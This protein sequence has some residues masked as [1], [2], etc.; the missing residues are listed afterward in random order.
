M[1]FLLLFGPLFSLAA[2]L[3]DDLMEVTV[4]TERD[5][6]RSED[7]VTT[8]ELE[9]AKQETEGLGEVLSRTPGLTV[10]RSGGLGSAQRIALD[11]F[12]GEQIRTFIDGVPL[13][14]SGVALQL[15][16]V[17]LELVDAVD[18]FHG[19]VPIRYGADALG[20]AIDLRTRELT[21]G[22]HGRVSFQAGSWDSYRVGASLR[23]LRHRVGF[24]ADATLDSSRNDWPITVGVADLTG[25]VSDLTVRRN[26]AAYLAGTGRLGLVVRDKPW[27]DSFD[28]HLSGS[29]SEKELPHNLVMTV[30]YGE[31]TYWRNAASALANWSKW[32]GASV[33]GYAMAAY[34]FRQTRLLDVAP[35]V[36]GWNGEIIRERPT[37]GELDN[38]P[39]DRVTWQHSFYGRLGAQALVHRRHCLDFSL[40]PDLAWRTGSE[41]ERE[42][43]DARDPGDA[44][45]Q[46]TKFVAGLAWRGELAPDRVF[47][48][49]FGKA[50]FFDARMEG[51]SPSYEFVEQRVGGVRGGGGALLRV[52]LADPLT[53]KASY[54]LATRIPSADE[55][56]GDGVLI[57][58]NLGLE[59]ETSH[60]ANLELML[61]GA[62]TTAGTFGASVRGFARFSDSLM[63]LL[64]QDVTLQWVNVYSA[65][66]LGVNGSVDWSSPGDWVSLYGSVGWNDMRNISDEGS[67]SNFKGDRIPNQPWLDAYGRLS[68]QAQD[69]GVEGQ[70]LRL[71][72]QTQYVHGY[73][74][75][76]ESVGQVASKQFVPSQL[77][78]GV[79]V[80]WST[81]WRDQYGLSATIEVANLTNAETYDLFGVQLAG[82]SVSA[83]L[84]ATW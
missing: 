31:V 17:P 58:P 53:L 57:L 72:W 19:V 68:F 79:G 15:S 47:L 16:D 14:Y 81:R 20:G 10:Q 46:L 60:N 77:V 52:Q 7:A 43:N 63:V 56:F 29:S 18:V 62:R 13:A 37:P 4:E 59:P 41:R 12:D 42:D 61:A 84:S 80:T 74:R 73:F 33:Q 39:H 54:E 66:T 69:L 38:K 44:D 32:L 26:H 78:H 11:G 64:P 3:D 34:G 21:E 49:A 71:L 82:R 67:F 1:G 70:S 30:P 23:Y 50:Y 75:G 83:K 2:D 76:W 55:W 45:Q 5:Q 9:E 51:L 28:F 27:A 22:L 25:A 65:R 48:K 40:T 24:V 36:Y 8:V 35:Y 6:A